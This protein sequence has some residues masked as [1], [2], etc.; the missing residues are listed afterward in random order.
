MKFLFNSNNDFSFE[1]KKF[2]SKKFECKSV[3]DIDKLKL[4]ERLKLEEIFPKNQERYY[5]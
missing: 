5:F 1:I 2:K 3:V 4:K